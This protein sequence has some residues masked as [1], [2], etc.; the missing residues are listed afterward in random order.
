[1]KQYRIKDYVDR[2]HEKVQK[3]VPNLSKKTVKKVL[4]IYSERIKKVLFYRKT[5]LID[6][7]FIIEPHGRKYFKKIQKRNN[8]NN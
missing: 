4:S 8:I 2:V 5:L 7:W 6:R 3:D 1:M